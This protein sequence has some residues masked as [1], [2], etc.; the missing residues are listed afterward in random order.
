MFIARQPIFKT[1]QS[2]YGYE[3]LFRLNKQSK[4]FEG[5]SS[6]CATA[7]VLGGLFESGIEAIVDDK[8]AFIN[9]DAAFIHSEMPELIDP[10]KLII[11]VLEDVL[12]DDFL[13]AR[14]ETLKEKGYKIALDDFVESYHDYP[15]VPLSDII[16][17]DIMQTPLDAL[18][19]V[20]QKALSQNKLLLAEKIETEADF[21]KAKEMGFHLFQ[22]YFFS[23]PNIVG[24]STDRTTTKTQYGRLLTELR[25]DEPSYQ[26]LAEIVEKDVTM[27]YRLMRVVKTRSGDDL[28]YS[29]KRALTYMGLK[30]L[31]R[32]INILMIRE[33]ADAKPKEL[34][35]LSLFRTRFA[36]RV[37][38][39]SPKL[40]GM[41][42]EASMLGLFSTLDA[43]LDEP[44]INA[45]D[46]ISLPTSITDALLL[47]EGPLACIMVMIH[48]YELGDFIAGEACAIKIGLDEDQVYE[49]YKDAV[50]WAREIVALM[51]INEEAL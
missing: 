41:K 33:L 17:F 45:L 10:Q 28:V 50:K 39:A 26:A 38:Q 42:H 4:G 34:M 36:E 27:A 5:A 31:E 6:T 2:V 51:Y 35:R 15:L 12:V 43:M 49:H 22:G 23:K 29:I 21:I 48:A 16:K 19:G 18:N 25:K 3:L 47:K 20:V 13:I 37:A 11:E 46:G 24:Q 44:M 7:M 14:L 32:W 9:F 30:E 1:D 40:K 8:R